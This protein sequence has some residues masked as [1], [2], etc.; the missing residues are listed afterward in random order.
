MESILVK[1][2]FAERMKRYCEYR[3]TK[4]NCNFFLPDR[5]M[6]RQYP[7]LKICYDII[8]YERI[9]SLGYKEKSLKNEI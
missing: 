7:E 6:E 5:L 9:K 3:K 2:G 4:E 8:G 1:E